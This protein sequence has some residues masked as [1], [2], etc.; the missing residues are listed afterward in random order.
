MDTL[1]QIIIAASYALA[2]AFAV[3]LLANLQGCANFVDKHGNE[4]STT[5][6]QQYAGIL[7]IDATINGAPLHLVSGK[8][9]QALVVNGEFG[10]DG[11]LTSLHISAQQI[12]AFEGQAIS[13]QAVAAITDTIFTRLSEAGVNVTRAVVE[14]AVKAALGGL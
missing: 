9:S 5:P 6:S 12:E 2:L 4:M 10:E 11:T 14:G 7:E 8:E 13:A 1:K 3:V